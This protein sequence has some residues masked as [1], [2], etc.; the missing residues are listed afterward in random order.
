MAFMATMKD[1]GIQTSWH[2]PPVHTFSSY[3]KD[4]DLL[5]FTLPLTEALA[6]REVTLP[7]YPTMTEEQVEWVVEAI[8]HSS[9][10]F[11][12]ELKL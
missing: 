7:L 9:K 11:A 3:A 8:I 6:A 1:K 12:N 2:Y 5:S 4:M 10:Q